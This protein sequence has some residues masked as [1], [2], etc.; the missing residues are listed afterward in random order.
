MDE[1]VTM[2][3]EQ[4]Y[5]ML[6][7]IF[8][9]NITG[10]KAPYGVLS[11]LSLYKEWCEKYNKP[12]PDWVNY[13]QCY[14]EMAELRDDYYAQNN[15]YKLPYLFHKSVSECYDKIYK[16]STL[17]LYHLYESFCERYR[18]QAVSKVMWAK[19]WGVSL[20]ALNETSC[21]EGDKDE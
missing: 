6:G 16:P 14:L 4:Y 21:I 18:I 5:D 8:V 3:A 17:S 12:I 15:K 10:D 13:G 7:T 20:R 19:L 2:T 11:T 1:N 9:L